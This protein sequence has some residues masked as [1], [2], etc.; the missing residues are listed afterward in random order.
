[1]TT[2]SRHR[3]VTRAPSAATAARTEDAPLT[4]ARTRIVGSRTGF[5]ADLVVLAVRGW[6]EVRVGTLR[7]ARAIRSVVT[8]LGW[9]MLAL[10]VLAFG[11]GYLAGW[12]EA[13]PVAWA[14]LVVLAVASLFL[15]GGHARR[16]VLELPHPRVVVGQTAAGRITER[17]P[18]GHRLLGAT[19][20][21]PVGDRFL[22]LALP[23]LAPRGEEEQSFPIPAER[24]GVV[25]IGP[26]RSVRADPLGLVRREHLWDTSVELFVHPRTVPIASTSTGFVRD[27]EGQATRDLTASD[28]AFHALREYQP[29]D[30]RRYIHWKSTAKQ[31]VHM[32]REFEQTR[33]SHLLVA[34]SLA[35][36]DYENEEQFELAVS[37][38]GSLGVRALR[39]A[40]TVSVVASGATPEFAKRKVLSVRRL[41]TLTPVRLLDDL[42]RVEMADSALSLVDLARVAADQV[43]GTSVAFLVFGSPPAPAQL[44][45]ASASF[46]AGVE[47]VAV[48]CDPGFT[49]ALRRVA[50][51]TV[52]TIGFLDDLQKAL[53]RSRAA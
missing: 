42:A 49:P 34:L 52:L 15:L 9:S 7:A 43:A 10:T 4:N 18:T 31:G 25:T 33:R 44:R 11:A 12:D 40:R 29:G 48:V 3:S 14:G 28:V 39:D 8:P 46:P 53:A 13:V 5:V 41:S 22:E 36:A 45:A 51:L 27:L 50:G 16:V 32:V 26:V 17:N 23:A 37:V 6:R 35:S 24:R 2:T 1:V 21:V 38:A 30:D 20:E 19:V 47:V